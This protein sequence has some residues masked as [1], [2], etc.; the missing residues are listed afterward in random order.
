MTLKFLAGFIVLL[1][2][3]IL[4]FWFAWAGVPID[5][6]FAALIAFAFIFD[7][8]QLVVLILFAMFVL[9]WQAAASPEILVIAFFPAAAYFCRD[10]IHWEPWIQALGTI[11][12]GFVVLS[13]AADYH[14]FHPESIL[15]DACGA[16]LFVAAVFFPLH[17]WHDRAF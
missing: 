14:A 10:L 4:Q 5:F 7:L 9:N 17:A 11:I 2:A 12:F 8:S 13:L 15:V 1:I 6:S 3:L 16:L